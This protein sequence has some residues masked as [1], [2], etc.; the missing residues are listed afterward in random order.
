MSHAEELS[1]EFK[2]SLNINSSP[3]K[4]AETPPPPSVPFPLPSNLQV[5]EPS[6]PRLPPQMESVR[7]HTADEIIKTVNKTPLFMTS[8]EDASDGMPVLLSSPKN[9]FI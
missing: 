8:L 1:E 9:L 4:D 6:L 7:S 5:G 2:E 3:S